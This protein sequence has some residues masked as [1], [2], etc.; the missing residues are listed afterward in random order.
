MNPEFPE[1]VH[2]LNGIYN[3]WAHARRSFADAVK[4][5]DKKDPKTVKKSVAYQALQFTVLGGRHSVLERPLSEAK[6]PFI[7]AN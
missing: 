5:A 7:L 2:Y 3:C 6:R 1:K 4:I